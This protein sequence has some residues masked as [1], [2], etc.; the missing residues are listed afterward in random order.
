MKKL[1]IPMLAAI[2][3]VSASAFTTVKNNPVK[4]AAAL[5]WY[6]VTYDASHPTGTIAASSDFYVQSEKSQVI[7]PCVAGTEKDC[8]RGFAS[9][10]TTYPNN[11]VG[12]D[13][14]KRPDQ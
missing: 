12:T 9:A 6:E 2:M 10:L 11:A 5:Y 1:I 13:Q 7:S 14:I 4:K 8:L 3:A